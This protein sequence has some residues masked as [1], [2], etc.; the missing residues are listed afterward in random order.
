MELCEIKAIARKAGIKAGSMKKVELIRAVQRAEG[1][2]DCFLTEHLAVCGR[3][4]CLW[5]EDCL[6]GIAALSLCRFDWDVSGEKYTW[7][8][9]L[10]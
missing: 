3:T 9:L 5:R 2:N 1:N 4:N 7:E 10:W 8:S 6:K